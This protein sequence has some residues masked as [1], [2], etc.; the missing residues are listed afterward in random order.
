MLHHKYVETVC[1]VQD[2]TWISRT[3]CFSLDILTPTHEL[4]P[5][6]TAIIEEPSDSEQANHA[7]HDFEPATRAA[8]GAFGIWRPAEQH[9][10]AQVTHNI[11]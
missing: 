6:A 1:V 11:T 9:V 2:I 8:S 4:Q 7:C 3:P 5:L 10:E